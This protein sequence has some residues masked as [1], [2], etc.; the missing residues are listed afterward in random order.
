MDEKVKESVLALL[1]AA[2]A[3]LKVGNTAEAA[4]KIAEAKDKIKPIGGGSLGPERP[5]K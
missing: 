5:A 4:A 1:D 3:E 2:E